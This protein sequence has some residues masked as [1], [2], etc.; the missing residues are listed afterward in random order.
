LI[1][2]LFDFIKILI[3]PFFTCFLMFEL[4]FGLFPGFRAER[5]G[6]VQKIALG[7]G[8]SAR[9]PRRNLAIFEICPLMCLNPQMLPL[10]TRVAAEK[11]RKLDKQ[12]EKRR[13]RSKNN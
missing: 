5:G 3:V 11:T 8:F 6:F 4:F 7:A 10:E 13:K 2:I 1:F 9:R 12:L